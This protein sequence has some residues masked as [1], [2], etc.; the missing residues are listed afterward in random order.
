MRLAEIVRVLKP[1]DVAVLRAIEK[2]SENYRYVPFDAL[3]R[4]L[5]LSAV[6]LEKRLTFLHRLG[7]IRRWTGQYRGYELKTIGF[8]AMALYSL[9]RRGIIKALGPKLGVGKESD[10]YEALS[11]EGERVAIKFLRAGTRSFKH[12]RRTR[13]YK[14]SRR[15][16]LRFK[17]AVIAAKREYE[18]LRL[19]HPAGVSVPEPIAR[20]RHAIVMSVIEGDPLYVCDVLPDPKGL[21]EEVVRNVLVAYRE[22]KV[23]HGELS[24]YNIIV[25]P[26]L[27]PL[28]IDWP[29][30]I[31]SSH[32]VAKET[33]LKDLERV[34][35]FFKRRFG[36]N[37]S[38]EA[39]APDVV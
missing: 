17:G 26:S 1:A 33:L 20:S 35:A 25:T 36:I 23:V 11:G 14:I 19:L 31:P 34:T 15:G 3:Q 22:A 39:L 13:V 27:H 2:A 30:W 28:I 8:D 5:D 7:L 10:V 6:T 29:Q 16:I 38:I 24:E 37:V 4:M 18:A 12:V 21:L 32:P 9:S